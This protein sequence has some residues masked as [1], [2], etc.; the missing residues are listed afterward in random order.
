MSN[1]A[2]VTIYKSNFELYLGERLFGKFVNYRLNSPEYV[3]KYLYDIDK[4][5]LDFIDVL[6]PLVLLIILLISKKKH[7]L[8]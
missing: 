2:N 3:S 4:D 1:I 5:A 6:H 7:F 8:N